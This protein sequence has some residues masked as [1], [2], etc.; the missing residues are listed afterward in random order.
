MQRNVWDGHELRQCVGDRGVR[1][2]LEGGGPYRTT[3]GCAIVVP[4][5][6]RHVKGVIHLHENRKGD[7][8]SED[9]PPP[10]PPLHTTNKAP[11]RLPLPA[12]VRRVG[13]AVELD[14]PVCI[15]GV[16]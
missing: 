1:K 9:T 11:Y 15:C 5:A 13:K 14:E 3:R 16:I 12:G 8:L 7:G 6:D 4:V 10:L 2:V